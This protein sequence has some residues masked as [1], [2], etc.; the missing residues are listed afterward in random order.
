MACAQSRTCRWL[1]PV[2]QVL[3]GINRR[4]SASRTNPTNRRIF[5]FQRENL[6]YWLSWGEAFSYVGLTSGPGSTT[7]KIVIPYFALPVWRPTLKIS[8]SGRWM[9]SLRLL[10]LTSLTESIREVQYSQNVGMSQGGCS[11]HDNL[12]CHHTEYW[13]MSVQRASMRED[14]APTVFTENPFQHT[15]PD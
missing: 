8:F 4:F 11:T 3:M 5:P 15:I 1:R 9:L 2:V 13:W 6:V 12:T 14:G 10:L 7:V